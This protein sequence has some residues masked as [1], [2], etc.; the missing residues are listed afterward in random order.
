MLSH[1]FRLRSRDVR[2]LTRKRNYFVKG[3]FGFFYIPQYA[4]KPFN[5][6]SCHITIKLSKHATKRNLIKR[7]IMNILRDTNAPHLP[8]GN[9]FYKVFIMLNK[10]Q[11][12]HL[13]ALLQKKGALSALP[14]ALNDT[15]K[16][17]FQIS[18]TSFQSFLCSKK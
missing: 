5:Q 17:A 3:W 8:F 14:P 11:L 15:V 9:Q 18:F 6:F 13:Q 16:Q 4:K 2:Y 7:M 10:S 12:P 1:T